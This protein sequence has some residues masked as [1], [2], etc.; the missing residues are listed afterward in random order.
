MIIDMIK[1]TERKTGFCFMNCASIFID[2]IN[3]D[4]IVPVSGQVPMEGLKHMLMARALSQRTEQ[5]S[6]K[7]VQKIVKDFSKKANDLL[8]DTKHEAIQDLRQTSA[9]NADLFL[10][11]LRS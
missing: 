6:I 11:L 9:T 10:S 8:C 7:D 2:M 4:D 1:D 5:H 3:S